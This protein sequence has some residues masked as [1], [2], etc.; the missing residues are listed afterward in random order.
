MTKNEWFPDSSVDADGW[1]LDTETV[2]PP[3]DELYRALND[4]T[5]REILYLLSQQSTMQIDRLVERVVGLRNPDL[6]TQHTD[7]KKRIQ[8]SLKHVHLPLLADVG[9][10]TYDP[11]D[12]EVALAQLATPVEELIEFTNRYEQAVRAH[13]N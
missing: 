5:S 12:G 1:S 4:R 6:A 2:S 13:R 9:L 7:D 10:L 8:T 11:A 3:P